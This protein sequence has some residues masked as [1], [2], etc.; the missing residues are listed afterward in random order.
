MLR[1]A[2]IRTAKYLAARDSGQVAWQMY[3]EGIGSYTLYEQVNPHMEH[4]LAGSYCLTVTALKTS[5]CFDRKDKDSIPVS[6]SLQEK[7]ASL[8]FFFDLCT[9]NAFIYVQRIALA[10]L[11]EEI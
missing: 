10:A 9:F 3:W 11:L 2:M 1:D 6:S 5:L 8:V 4:C 7:K